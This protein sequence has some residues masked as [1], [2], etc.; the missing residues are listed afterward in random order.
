MPP[1]ST[2]SRTLVRPAGTRG[3][4]KRVDKL[5][6][7]SQA[8]IRRQ[9]VNAAAAS[10]IISAARRLFVRHGFED[11]SMRQIASAAK[12]TPGA[13][14]VHFQDK[15]DLIFAMLKQDFAAFD[16]GMDEAFKIADPVERLRLMG[17]GYV[18]FALEHP[19]HYKLMFMTEPPADFREQSEKLSHDGNCPHADS[20]REGYNACRMTV[21]ECMQQGRFAPQLTDLEKVTQAT[22][23]CVH[24]VAS[25]FI[26]HGQMPWARFTD[27]LGAAFT[28]I[29]IH[30][31]GMTRGARVPTP[32][33]DGGPSVQYGRE[34]SG[35]AGQQ[36]SG[37]EI[38]PPHP[39]S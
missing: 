25:L 35:P 18:R 17:R 14:Y 21:A 37:P 27:P 1:R 33:M 12:Y 39:S 32:A 36:A 7:T 4:G 34:A 11:V 6:D 38:H 8:A 26:T 28:A 20:D 13:L 24:G 16:A 9:K 3:E 31:A 10:R 30:L 22:W 29:D 5:L 15:R 19:H 2:S 23:G